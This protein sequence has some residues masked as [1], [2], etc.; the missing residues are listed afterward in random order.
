MN[1]N[2]YYKKSIS[3]FNSDSNNMPIYDLDML[4]I[5]PDEYQK[6][7]PNK[8]K[9]MKLID[10]LGNNFVK[11]QKHLGP[12]TPNISLR[13]NFE[14]YDK[15]GFT[16]T[17][18]QLCQIIIPNVEKK[19]YN[20]FVT[21]DMA[22]LYRNLIASNVK[23]ISSWLWHTDHHAKEQIKII[24][25]LTDVD[26]SSGAFEVM[27][28]NG[29]CKKIESFRKDNKSWKQHGVKD[30]YPGARIPPSVIQDLEK[31]GYKKTK[32][33]GP[34]GTLILFDNNIAHK[35]NRCITKCRDILNIELRPSLINNKKQYIKINDMTKY[36]Q[37]WK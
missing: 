28:K 20:S 13:Y 2:E 4:V 15:Y 32:I 1:Y 25:Y 3:N 18:E 14:D 10:E 24:F 35:A 23:D 33:T 8:S 34:K 6:Y 16:N 11:N 7:F 26:E 21:I 27:M 31:E 17:I 37:N 36:W 19:I 22:Y 30:P 12:N 5:K 29:R 9:F